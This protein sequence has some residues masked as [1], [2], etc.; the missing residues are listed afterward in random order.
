L[1]EVM[2]D[3]SRIFNGDETGFQI[4]PSTGPVFAEKGAKNMYST[5]EGSSKENITVMFSFSA[6][7]KKCCPMIVYP[8]KR[9]KL[10]IHHMMELQQLSKKLLAAK[11]AAQEAFLKSL[12]S[13]E[14]KCW[15]EFYKYVKRRKENR[16]NIPAIKDS[17]GRI[18]TDSIHKAN[19]FNSYYSTVFSSEGNIPQMQGESTGEPF[20]IDINIIRRRIRAIG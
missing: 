10:G 8:Y 19:S 9:K 1:E 17:Y 15:S 7:G 11:K 13:R 6:N 3:P 20:T 16:E 18:I 14:G 5:D 12:L 2:D 4:C